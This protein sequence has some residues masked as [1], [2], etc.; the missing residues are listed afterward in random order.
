WDPE[1]GYRLW[2]NYECGQQLQDDHETYQRVQ[3]EISYVQSMP[4]G[5]GYFSETRLA[6][7]AYG[8]IGDPS[9]A[10]L[11]QLGGPNRIRGLDWN[12]RDG[13]ALW[14]ATAE[15]RFPIW[16]DIDCDMC[17][18]VLR[19]KHMY[20]VAFYDT[21]EVFSEGHS[22]GGIVHSVGTGLRMDMAVFSF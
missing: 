7:R 1:A 9:N 13:S 22:I 5:L 21:G 11:F 19:L 14:I 2:I 3:G 4:S 8:G 20:G 17:D 16:R 6:L 10:Q 12:T 18:H 15:W